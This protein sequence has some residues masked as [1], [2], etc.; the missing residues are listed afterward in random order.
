MARGINASLDGTS[1]KK[2]ILKMAQYNK[3]VNFIFRL[4]LTIEININNL[5]T[6]LKIELQVKSVYNRDL[7]LGQHLY[8]LPLCGPRIT[9][10]PYPTLFKMSSYR[11]RRRRRI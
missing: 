11:S 4:V 7:A 9:Q 3:K 6:F 5:S 2:I 1:L 10:V 8:K